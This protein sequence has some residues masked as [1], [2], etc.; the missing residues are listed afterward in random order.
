M[1]EEDFVKEMMKDDKRVFM[2]LFKLFSRLD[3]TGH[4]NQQHNNQ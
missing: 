4:S 1:F 3:D 2:Q